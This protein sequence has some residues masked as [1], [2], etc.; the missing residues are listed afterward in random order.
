M[1]LGTLI[2]QL[3]PWHVARDQYLQAEQL[4]FDI[5]Y[6][7][8]HIT[9]ATMKGAWLADGWT[10]LAAAAEATSRIE[11][12]TMVASAAVRNPVAM[13]RASATLQDISGGRFL[14]GLGAGTA[15][16]AAADRGVLPT[17]GELMSRYA[18]VVEAY[19]ALQDGATEWRGEFVA[20]EGVFTAPRPPGSEPPPLL[21]VGH[22]PRGYRLAVRHAAAWNTY[23]GA[24]HAGSP[25]DEFL[26]AVVAQR[27]DVVRTCEREGRDPATLRTSVLI[28]FGEYAP[29]KSV[30][31]FLDVA[32][33]LGAAGF[34]ELVTYWPQGERGSRFWADLEVIADG[35]RQIKQSSS[36]PAPMSVRSSEAV[37]S[38]RRDT[39]AASPQ[40][41]QDR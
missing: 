27:E 26:G 9:H 23:G 16:D 36:E 39:P 28:G 31:T 30:A 22:G 41:G 7:A 40:H 21:L 14:L 13:L 25:K 17:T 38:V 29:L 32:E 11:L 3:E 37:A 1:R 10:T 8:D 35:I 19:V 24:E 18:E 12:G 20:A 33:R 6:A 5:A 34:D 2:L 4:G 15:A